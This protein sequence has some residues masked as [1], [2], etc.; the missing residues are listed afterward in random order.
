MT[1]HHRRS[2]LSAF[3]FLFLSIVGVVESAA[4][5]T[6]DAAASHEADG[7]AAARFGTTLPTLPLPNFALGELQ[8]KSDEVATV[9]AEQGILTLSVPRFKETKDE[10]FAAIA[11]CAPNSAVSKTENGWTRKSLAGAMQAGTLKRFEGVTEENCPGFQAKMLRFRELVRNAVLNLL[12]ALDEVDKS[13]DQELTQLLYTA[14]HLEHIHHVVKATGAPQ[15]AIGEGTG[16]AVGNSNLPRGSTATAALETDETAAAVSSAPTAATGEATPRTANTDVLHPLH[17]DAGLLLAMTNLHQSSTVKTIFEIELADESTAVVNV[18]NLDRLLIMGGLGFN[19]WHMARNGL[20]VRAVPHRVRFEKVSDTASAGQTQQ[21][22]QSQIQGATTQNQDTVADKRLW[23]GMM[24]LPPQN[25]DIGRFGHSESVPFSELATLLRKGEYTKAGSL[26]CGPGLVLE[27]WFDKR[28]QEMRRRQLGTTRAGGSGSGTSG[29]QGHQQQQQQGTSPQVSAAQNYAGDEPGFLHNLRTGVQQHFAP[30]QTQLVAANRASSGPDDDLDEEERERQEAEAEPESEKNKHL[31]SVCDSYGGYWCWHR[32]MYTKAGPFEE[33]QQKK[34]ERSEFG[35]NFLYANGLEQCPDR[36]VQCV[37]NTPKLEPCKNGHTCKLHCDVDRRRRNTTNPAGAP[38][39]GNNAQ[40]VNLQEPNP[41]CG[42]S[43][44]D[45]FMNG[46]QSIL[47]ASEK[48]D[49]I[50]LFHSAILLDTH[51]KF[52]LGFL[53]IVAFGVF[54]EWIVSV[55]RKIDTDLRTVGGKLVKV[56]LFAA[57]MTIG[58]LIMLLT[59][60]YSFELFLAVILGLAGGHFLFNSR[61]PVGES[62]T[63][64]CAGRNNPQGLRQ[65]LFALEEQMRDNEGN[66]GGRTVAIVPPGEDDD[67]SGI[68][69]SDLLLQR[70]SGIN[71]S[72]PMGAGSASL[73]Q[74]G[75]SGSGER[76]IIGVT[77]MTCGNCEM[78]VRNALKVLPCVDQ[79]HSV[80]FAQQR[81]DCTIQHL[82]Q[83]ADVVEEIESLGFLVKQ[84]VPASASRQRGA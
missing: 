62:V 2:G 18:D 77:G 70:G 21:E 48:Q 83:R 75:G 65:T 51:W 73:L 66:S 24:L 8:A 32:C 25:Y 41:F 29:Q 20:K 33:H 39:P 74:N 72:Q 38:N 64:C 7:T 82:E 40:S 15:S 57:N 46:F 19:N 13:E 50:M 55:R 27:E 42:P 31:R 28:E 1:G 68:K 3:A 58:Y 36:D 10:A 47:F 11:S 34:Q 5:A 23:Y 80:S 14:Q 37:Y 67:G 61:A 6:S 12:Q 84:A 60:T 63:A 35:S 56:S 22:L 52:A 4:A 54:T 16:T 17:V 78:T 43:E 79:V 26:A 44:T 59:M 45:M 76:I 69:D 30:P 81:V 9:L 71:Q 53:F 49:C